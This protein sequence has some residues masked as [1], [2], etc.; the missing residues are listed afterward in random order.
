MNVSPNWFG[1]DRW[2]GQGSLVGCRALIS[3]AKRYSGISLLQSRAPFPI[4]AV[5]KPDY[6][7]L[8]NQPLKYCF[9]KERDMYFRYE[10]T[11]ISD[12]WIT[13]RFYASF[14]HKMKLKGEVS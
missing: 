12:C 3:S 5:G 7:F 9:E 6:N 10:R 11:L 8:T 2:R 1:E 13:Y 14:M 4:S